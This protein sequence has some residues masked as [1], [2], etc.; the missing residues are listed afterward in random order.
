[1]RWRLRA[2]RRTLR[3]MQYVH[4]PIV[5]VDNGTKRGLRCALVSL[6]DDGSADV[7]PLGQTVKTAGGRRD[8]GHAV[9]RLSDGASLASQVT[10]QTLPMPVVVSETPAFARAVLF[11][12][13]YLALMVHHGNRTRAAERIDLSRQAMTDRVRASG[14]LDTLFPARDGR[15]PKA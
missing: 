7:I 8:R 5:Q 12:D 9:W 15:P 13:A 1:M 14:W 10:A 3:V 4:L 6:H 11:S 2:G